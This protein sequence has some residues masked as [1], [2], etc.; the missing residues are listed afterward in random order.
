[1]RVSLRHDVRVTCVVTRY[2]FL[3]RKDKCVSSCPKEFLLL[4]VSTVKSGLKHECIIYTY[5]KPKS[6]KNI[7]VFQALKV[8]IFRGL[9][10][11]CSR[12]LS[13]PSQRPSLL[14]C[15]LQRNPLRTASSN[16]KTN[17]YRVVRRNFFYC[18]F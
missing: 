10:S 14:Y 2:S 3:K 1:M 6:K 17:V 11:I 7:K 18:A 9:Y 5:S 4:C 16:A 12:S 8:N 13:F 15:S